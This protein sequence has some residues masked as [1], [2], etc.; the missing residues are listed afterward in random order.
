MSNVI[1]IRFAMLRRARA[2]PVQPLDRG[3]FEEY[4]RRDPR[5]R[6]VARLQALPPARDRQAAALLTATYRL[7]HCPWSLPAWRAGWTE[8][9]LFSIEVGLVLWLLSGNRFENIKP[10]RAEICDH[11]GN[12]INV[13]RPGTSLPAWFDDP[14]V[15]A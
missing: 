11:E 9:C 8:G 10:D 12:R 2:L 14:Q 13:A 1:D 4:L 5:R 15:V 7:V 3:G 6:W